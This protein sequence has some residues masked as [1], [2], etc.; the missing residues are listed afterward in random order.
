MTKK[1]L[2]LESTVDEPVE[3]PVISAEEYA[4]AS[5]AMRSSK[6]NITEGRKSI[7]AGKV[8]KKLPDP[9]IPDPSEASEIGEYAGLDDGDIIRRD[10]LHIKKHDW[11]PSDG[12][13]IIATMIP[14]E[15]ESN[16]SIMRMIDD[17]RVVWTPGR[18]SGSITIELP[19]G[20][21]ERIPDDER[22]GYALC[23]VDGTP[24]VRVWRPAETP[25]SGHIRRNPDGSELIRASYVPLNDDIIIDVQ[26][27][28]QRIC[29]AWFPAYYPDNCP[30]IHK[31]DKGTL[32]DVLGRVARING[33]INP[34]Y[35]IAKTTDWD[36]IPRMADFFITLGYQIPESAGLTPEE[37]AYFLRCCA[38][39]SFI[40]LM[41]RQIHPM[42]Y[43]LIL[44]LWGDPGSGKTI[45]AEMMGNGFYGTTGR[46]PREKT[47]TTDREF[48]KR[49]EGRAVCCFDEGDGWTRFN[50]DYLKTLASEKQYS[51]VEK[52][53]KAE[54]I[55]DISCIFAC[56]T[57]DHHIIKDPDGNTRRYLPLMASMDGHTIPAKVILE[58]EKTDP[59]YIDQIYA[60]ALC[61]IESAIDDGVE[62][63]IWRIG[64]E[65]GSYADDDKFKRIQKQVCTESIEIDGTVQDLADYIKDRL[66]SE[67]IDAPDTVKALSIETEYRNENYNAV[68]GMDWS[69]ITKTLHKTAKLYGL[70]YDRYKLDGRT[71]CGYRLD[72]SEGSPPSSKETEG[73]PRRRSRE[74][75]P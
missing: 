39:F 32:Q 5:E 37:E 9:I 70:R 1:T 12:S 4:Q 60:E 18:S 16:E 2:H 67:S 49:T 47:S 75:K 68:A 66:A 52:Y 31:I 6:A 71:I 19:E 23:T 51:Y 8:T 56:T 54:T 63:Q 34:I 24:S 65:S 69:G 40:G 30:R 27:N 35:E 72:T 29:R 28:I 59:G 14:G 46:V 25:L 45:T 64:D 38:R 26:T 33:P 53:E 11:D 17:M 57:N 36:G 3:I 13:D 62:Y 48:W 21:S 58:M 61:T 74:A 50:N 10:G 73:T 43:D 7:K 15:I 44:I 22:L 42:L 41:E 20:P 55:H